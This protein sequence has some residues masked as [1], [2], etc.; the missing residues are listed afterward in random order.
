V[1]G[2]SPK[3]TNSK[4]TAVKKSSQ[5]Q[6]V[7]ASTLPERVSVAMGEIA[8]N[9]HQGL[10]VLAVGAGLQVMAALMEADVSALAGQRAS[11]TRRSRPGQHVT[12][13]NRDDP[14]HTVTADANNVFGVENQLRRRHVDIHR[15]R[16]RAPTHFT[17]NSMPT[18]KAR[19]LSSLPAQSGRPATQAG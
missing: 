15:T 9:I 6:R 11:T 13:V 17:A 16:H 7:G 12:I 10:L 3:N 5:I 8:E 1:S 2:V 14:N 18:C 19:L 4:G